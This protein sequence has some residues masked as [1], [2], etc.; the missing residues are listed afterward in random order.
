MLSDLL[1]RIWLASGESERVRGRELRRRG[2]PGGSRSRGVL[3]SSR[4]QRK[5]RIVLGG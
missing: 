1:V 3:A 5:K 4:R 2:E